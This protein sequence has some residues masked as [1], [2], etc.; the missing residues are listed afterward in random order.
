MGGAGGNVRYRTRDQLAFTGGTWAAANTIVIGAGENLAMVVISTGRARVVYHA[1]NGAFVPNGPMGIVAQN[2][3]GTWMQGQ[4]PSI[5]GV[6]ELSAD[7]GPSDT[8]LA[9]YAS[10]GDTR[11]VIGFDATGRWT[12]NSESLLSP[13]RSRQPA[14]AVEPSG[15]MHVVYYDNIVQNSISFERANAMDENY[16]EIETAGDVGNAPSIDLDS[17]GIAHVVYYNGSG[18]FRYARVQSGS[19]LETFTLASG[20]DV[21]RRS[22]LVVDA[23]DRVHVAYYDGVNANLVYRRR[24]DGVWSAA[25][26]V[27]ETG[28][29]GRY[30]N[31]AIDADG[32]THIVY[33]DWTN[34][35]LK[36]A[37]TR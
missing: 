24:I 4:D 23:F 26:I 37:S 10:S 25:Q 7:L 15:R 35:D 14:L 5:T 2:S 22:D 17:T 34:Q 20:A 12:G 28:D 9:F 27:D 6:I 36:Y 8:I 31:L 30:P 18:L 3:A 1:T 29:V 33:E 13:Q 19:V 11:S 21:G 16:R 32:H